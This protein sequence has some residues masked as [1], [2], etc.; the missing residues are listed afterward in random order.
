MSDLVSGPCIF[1][2]KTNYPPS[3]GGP[4]VCPSCDCGHF[5]AA[6]TMGQAKLITELQSSLTALEEE[7]KRLREALRP[8]AG[9]VFN[10]NGD[11]TVDTRSFSYDEIVAAYFVLRRARKEIDVAHKIAR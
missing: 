11:L 4:Q 3:L 7:N 9:R 5:S 10:D 1:C 2:G 6:T 8:F